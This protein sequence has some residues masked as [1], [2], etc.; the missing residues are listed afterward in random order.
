MTENKRQELKLIAQKISKFPN[1]KFSSNGI[2]QKFMRLFYLYNAKKCSTQEIEF[3][4][5]DAKN[6]LI[7][8]EQGKKIIWP[9]LI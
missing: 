5:E 1:S 4:L 6:T 2:S 8:L 7:E 3:F 9:V